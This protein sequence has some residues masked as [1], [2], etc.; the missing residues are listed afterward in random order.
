M[1]KING[2]EARKKKEKSQSDNIYF[3]VSFVSV[4]DDDISE[5]NGEWYTRL[6]RGERMVGVRFGVYDVRSCFGARRQ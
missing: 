4:H 1:G 2:T 6:D 5:H 3:Y